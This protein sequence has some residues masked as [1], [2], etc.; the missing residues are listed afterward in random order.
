[1]LYFAYGSNMS[2]LRLAARLSMAERV[3]VATLAGHRLAFHKVGMDGSAK[4]DAYCTDAPA[5]TVIGV[6][7]RIDAREKPVLDSIEGLGSGYAQKEV[8]L[9]LR[10]GGMLDAFTYY[11]TRIDEVLKPFAWY[12]RHVL[13]G[14]H[15][16]GLPADYIRGIEAAE[17]VAD[18]DA[19]RQV[20]EMSIYGAG[21]TVRGRGR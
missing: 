11:A 9:M 14:A 19:E 21:V 4:C 17:C 13:H 10:Q 12:K 5:D 6:V 3:A 15:E 1:M 8:R 20:L 2:T 7:F 16:H 18:P